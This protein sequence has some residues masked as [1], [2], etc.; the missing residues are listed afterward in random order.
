MTRKPIVVVGAGFFGLYI[1]EY[2]AKRGRDVLVLERAPQV[3]QGASFA[4]QARVHNGCHYPRS[5]LTALR[6]RVSFPRFVEEFSEC[7][8]DDFDQYYLIGKILGKVT[9]QQ[10]S[11]FCQRIGVRLDPAPQDI[12]DMANPQLVEAIFRTEEVAFNALT[13][14]DVMKQ[15]VEDAGVMVRTGI[16]V[17][18]IRESPRGLTVVARR[19][20]ESEPESIEASEVFVCTYSNTNQVLCGSSLEPIPLKHEVTE[21]CLVDVPGPLTRVGLT[22]MCGPFF[23][24]MPFP[25]TPHHSFSHVRYTPHSEWLETD[26]SAGA[27]PREIQ[28]STRRT[29][30]WKKIR[31][32]ARRY[33]PILD[34]C[35][36]RRSLWETKT[37]LPRS[38]IDDSRPILFKADHGLPGLHCVMGGKIDNIYDAL[39]L[40]EGLGL[41][42]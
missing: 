8:Q 28:D 33:I 26:C 25:S 14:A 29:S 6:C 10:F 31:Y 4:N 11:E 7:I 3:M 40:I 20:A 42:S 21:L 22:V 2:L 38:E 37:V 36:H 27:A 39:E 15:R 16:G 12:V 41:T 30:A 24:V 5:V 19:T 13:L 34:E 32:D 35:V 1:A 17:E 18:A 9:A 23:S